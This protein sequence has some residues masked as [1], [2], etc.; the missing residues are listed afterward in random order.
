MLMNKRIEKS[1][2]KNECMKRQLTQQSKLRNRHDNT[3]YQERL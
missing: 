3:E 1:K 2:K